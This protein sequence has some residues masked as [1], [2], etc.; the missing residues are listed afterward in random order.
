LNNE[1]TPNEQVD[2][3][4]TVVGGYGVF[5]SRVAE[6]LMRSGLCCVRIVGRDATV[7]NNL[8]H[9]IGAEFVP[10]DVAD[11]ATLQGAIE[12]SHIV[13]H[14]AGPFQSCD[15]HVAERCLDV[16]AHYLD[17]A[18]AREFVVGIDRLDARARERGLL[19]ASGVSSAPTITG[20]MVRDVI[21]QFNRVDKIQVALSPGNQNPRG[22]ATVGAILSYLGSPIRVWHD[23]AWT[24]QIGWGDA[25]RLQ[26]PPPVGWRR[27]HN[28][29]VPDLSLFPKTFAPRTV[30]FSAGLELGALNRLLTA[31]GW[32]CRLTGGR[33]TSR[34][35]LF[36][37]L[38]LMLFPFGSKHG[39]LAVWVRGRDH[40]GAAIE[41]RRAIVTDYDGPA[42][43]SSAS[44]ILAEKILTSGPPRTGACAGDG[45][46][47]LDEIVAHL[48]PLGVWCVHGDQHGWHA[49]DELRASAPA[50]G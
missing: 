38:S 9:R 23:G 32:M 34:A 50:G 11:D 13:I 21:D 27:V 20:A 35:N 30:Y 19:V 8:A 31:C 28:C 17:L 36:L 39:A 41:R 10:C 2:R 12:G 33:L 26:F 18:D 37:K 48:R 22:A 40:T 25:R 3:L 42:T 14:A 46:I 24:T 47:A 49:K 43:P 6:A 29:E 45:L 1:S 7:G 16:G 15:Y 44:I 4:V 5:G